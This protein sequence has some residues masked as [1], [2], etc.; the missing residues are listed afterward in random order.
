MRSPSAPKIQ[1]RVEPDPKA[2]ETVALEAV[3]QR[4][5]ESISKRGGYKSTM[6]TGGLGQA[7]TQ[8]ERALGA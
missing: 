7:R 1:Q 5:R 3:R 8:K 6:M 2:R 4:E